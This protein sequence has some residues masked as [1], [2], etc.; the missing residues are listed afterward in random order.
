AGAALQVQGGITVD[1]E[2]L[3]LN[4]TGIS[5]SGALRNVSG[6]NTWSGNITLASASSIGSS[7]NTITVTGNINNSGFLL[8]VTG[9]AS[10]TFSGAGV[11]SGAG[12]LTKNGGGT[13]TLSGTGGN[14]YTGAT[15]VAAGILNIQK[16]S[17]LGTNPSGTTVDSGA[18][19][20]LQGG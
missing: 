15:E 1:A 18:A 5:A 13:L 20:Q 9:A 2:P 10:T 8:T 14:T 12:G 11:L 16:A 17:A 19:L 4:G 3:T 7:A 6:N